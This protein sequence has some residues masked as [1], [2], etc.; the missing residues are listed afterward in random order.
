[1]SREEISVE[2]KDVKVGDRFYSE[3]HGRGVEV[4]EIEHY[5]T[6]GSVRIRSR[7]VDLFFEEH[8]AIDS[9]D[10]SRELRRLRRSAITSRM[11]S[12]AWRRSAASSERS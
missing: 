7:P 12:A 5:H 8:R 4:V 1:M 10:V 6:D 3:R 9:L 11:V 2:W